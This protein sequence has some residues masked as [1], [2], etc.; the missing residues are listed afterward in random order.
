MD[1]WKKRFVE[2]ITDV[3]EK[4]IK[5]GVINFQP[6]STNTDTKSQ[7]HQKITSF[8]DGKEEI[9][10]DTVSLNKEYEGLITSIK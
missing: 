10:F 2:S 8:L 9:S 4:P 3:S 6:V 5:Q 7:V 1:A